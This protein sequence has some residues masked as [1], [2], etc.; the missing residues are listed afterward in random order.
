MFDGHVR[1]KPIGQMLVLIGRAAADTD[2]WPLG[3]METCQCNKLEAGKS[4]LHF[5]LPLT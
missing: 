4:C 3:D 1:E 5:P 2:G